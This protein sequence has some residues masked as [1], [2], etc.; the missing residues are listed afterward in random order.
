M[1]ARHEGAAEVVADLAGVAVIADQL[2]VVCLVTSVPSLEVSNGIA[3]AV[4]VFADAGSYA[5]A[6][7]FSDEFAGT[8]IVPVA[9][10]ILDEIAAIA[11]LGTK[12][13]PRRSRPATTLPR[14]TSLR[15]PPSPVRCKCDVAAVS[16]STRDRVAPT[17]GSARRHDF[18]T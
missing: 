13:Q 10:S 5:S 15:S 16:R 9:L 6:R 14:T 18:A 1:A 4:A 17:S 11:I 2:P 8:L 7:A 12:S 3:L